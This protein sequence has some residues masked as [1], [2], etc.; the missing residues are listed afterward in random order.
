MA[1]LGYFAGGFAKGYGM[2]E[3]IGLRR[4]RNRREEEDFRYR[5]E[6]RDREKR[7]NEATGLELGLIGKQVTTDYTIQPGATG[8]LDE[9]GAWT[10]QTQMRT[11]E[12][13][14]ER[15]GLA[16]AKAGA[17]PERVAQFQA[18]GLQMQNAA[19]ENRYG[20]YAEK[21]LEF[22]RRIAAGEDPA[23]VYRE[24]AGLYNQVQDGKSAGLT[25]DGSE[26]I[27]FD[28][29]TGVA[30]KVPASPETFAKA[31]DAFHALSS[32]KAM[33]KEQ[34][35]VLKGRQVAAQESQAATAA[36]AQLSTADY[37]RSQAES[38]AQMRRDMAAHWQRQDGANGPKLAEQDKI[39]LTGL[40]RQE[41]TLEQLL[42][43]ADVSTPEGQAQ[44]L[45]IKGE[46][47]RVRNLQWD[48]YKKLKML[49]DHVTKTQFLGLPDPKLI[50]K[51]SMTKFAKNEK[52]FR[53]A[54]AAFDATY[55]D[56]PEASEARNE[57]EAFLQQNFSRVQ[58]QNDVKGILNSGP[59]YQGGQ[60]VGAGLRATGSMLQRR[61]ADSPF[62]GLP[63]F[64]G[65]QAGGF[66]NGLV[67]RQPREQ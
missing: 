16:M 17:K 29:G 64:L 34:D 11:P 48:H 7:I 23:A 61:A 32:P 37:Q 27:L 8:N 51:T 47:S 55:G 28:V 45:Q 4:D 25:E 39:Y 18:T 59:A 62:I 43:K 10:P 41:N 19:R 58:P 53:D 5:Q 56:A 52:G 63:R 12:Q 60:M 9:G 20:M 30:K 6:E 42:A 57:M 31:I 36:A 13:A 1:G 54:L 49:P 2:A 22:R 40:T 66:V 24:A 67:G 46:L 38:L 65:E 14:Y 33:E 35:H 3:E 15:A 26:L 44:V 21:A 50:A